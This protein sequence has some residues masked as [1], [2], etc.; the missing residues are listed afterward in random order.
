MS[1]PTSTGASID[2]IAAAY[3]PA[4]FEAAGQVV[5]DL[6]AQHLSD[7]HHSR[8]NVLNWRDPAANY[9][10]AMAMMQAE[11]SSTTSMTDRLAAIVRH[12]LSR[13][14]TLHD[15]RYIGHQVPP[16]LPVAAL[17]EAISAVTNQGMAIY[18]M[19]P[20]ASAAEEAMVRTLGEALGFPRGSFSGLITSG[21]SLANLTAL[22]TARNVALGEIWRRG[23]AASSPPPVIIS[24]AESHYCISRAAGVLGLG[25]DHV[26]KAALD[27]RF[28]MDPRKLDQTIG[29]LKA[30]SQPVIAVV[31]SACSTR[32]GAFDP[33]A[34]IA[35]VCAKHKLWLHVDAAHGGSACLSERYKHLVA[36]IE[37]ADSVVWDAH[38]MLLVP[39]LCTFVFYGDRAHRFSAFEQDAP[40]LYDPA[41]P[42]LADHDSGLK[43]VECT[44]R[45]AA[46][47][48]WGTW[49]L[50]GRQLFADIVERT[51]DFTRRF[52]DML[53]T[54]DDFTALHEPMCNILVFRC[55]PRAL[56]DAT[57]QRIG[58][59]QWALRRR[60]IE[61]GR[62]YLVPG[63]FDGEGALRIVIMNPLTTEDHLRG[64]LDELRRTAGEMLTP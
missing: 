30:K 11:A 23:L 25:S 31:A 60:V 33:I 35:D 42:D 1:Q 15:P 57:P 17:F 10:E 62:Y 55:V 43:T 34:D 20:W 3:D 14:Q 13:G 22:L 63:K 56:R 45:A 24:H 46:F 48:L 32:T 7:A 27:S 12:I 28:R 41:A 59:F 16:P 38:K 26:V 18:E 6:L 50:Y 47:G 54:S 8:G 29:E 2:R 21:G 53:R 52:H 36:G 9:A 5:V 37:R 39:A 40:Y 61:S 64:L 44:K 4:S 49:G 51:F 58:A 19:G